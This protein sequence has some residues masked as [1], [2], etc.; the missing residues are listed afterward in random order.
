[1]ESKVVCP[2]CGQ[3]IDNPEHIF[4]HIIG[5]QPIIMKKDHGQY[6]SNNDFMDIFNKIFKG[7]SGK[8]E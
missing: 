1:M 6:D 2:K 5:R 8:T 7:E 3:L 4:R